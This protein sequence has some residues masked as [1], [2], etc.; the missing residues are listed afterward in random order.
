MIPLSLNVGC[1]ELIP[2]RLSY[3]IH[4]LI[5]P[6]YSAISIIFSFVVLSY[7][8]FCFKPSLSKKFARPINFVLSDTNEPTTDARAIE[9]GR[10]IP[11]NRPNPL[12]NPRTPKKALVDDIFTISGSRFCDPNAFDV[13]LL[14]NAPIAPAN[15]SDN[16]AATALSR[17]VG[18]DACRTASNVAVRVSVTPLIAKGMRSASTALLLSRIP[19][20]SNQNIITTSTNQN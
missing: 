11:S 2:T 13:D 9:S 19:H 4:L 5:S 17:S 1:T 18:K 20:K 10:G 12:T 15:A 7:V 8:E 16:P 6:E 3:T 14:A